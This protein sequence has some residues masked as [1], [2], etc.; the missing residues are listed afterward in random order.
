MWKV[1]DPESEPSSKAALDAGCGPEW[2]K[3]R[4]ACAAPPLPAPVAEVVSE[5]DRVEAPQTVTLMTWNLEWFGDPSEGPVDDALQYDAVLDVLASEGAGVVA[6]QEVANEASFERLLAHLPG[7]A[8]ILSGY[9]WTQKTALLWDATLFELSH[10]RAISGL[11]DAGRPPL[12]VRLQRR[13]DGGELLIV[14]VHAKA[15][16]EARSQAIRARFVQGLKA[17]LDAEHAHSSRIVIGDFNDLLSGSLVAG[18]DTPYRPFLDDPAYAAPTRALNEPGAAET[19]Y[20]TGA[21]VD[22]ILVTKDLAPLV[23]R[24]SIDVLRDELLARYPRFIET[25]SDH[26]PV[27]LDLTWRYA[28]ATEAGAR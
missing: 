22:H 20:A 3:S 6:L 18:S 27:T 14:V 26:F 4:S 11:D 19:S 9:D 5:R 12:E 2:A 16:A 23:D 28:A 7:Y 10:A 21:T 25:V 17:H 13:W 15:Q 8:G 1:P 24:G